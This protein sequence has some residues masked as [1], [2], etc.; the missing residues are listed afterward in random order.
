MVVIDR[1]YFSLKKTR[2]NKN[3]FSYCK[4]FFNHFACLASKTSY[5]ISVQRT[6]P[7]QS[8]VP[9]H[10]ILVLR[11]DPHFC[12]LQPTAQKPPS[13]G[14]AHASTPAFSGFPQLNGSSP[15]YLPSRSWCW[16]KGMG[17]GSPSPSLGT[18]DP[19]GPGCP[20]P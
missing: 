5:W 14:A 19:L 20:L 16:W 3:T 13:L 1:Q 6:Q 12:L 7:Q 11:L 9:A 2:T 10:Q 17:P 4:L 15:R 8:S 18:L